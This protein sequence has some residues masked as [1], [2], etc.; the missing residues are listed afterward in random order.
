MSVSLILNERVISRSRV[1][2]LPNLPPSVAIVYPVEGGPF[3]VET[4]RTFGQRWFGKNRA[5]YVVDLS[6]HRR[7]ASV[8]K[9]PLTCKDGGHR[10]QATIDVGFR[11]HDP[12]MVV[13]RNVR[14]ALTVVYGYLTDRIRLQAAR[15]AITEAMAAQ[16]TVNQE[17]DREIRLPEGITI[18]YCKVQ[19]EPDQAAARH[20]QELEEARRRAKLGAHAHDARRSETYSDEDI[21]DIRAAGRRRRQAD[22]RAALGNTQLDFDNLIREHLVRHPEE[23]THAL[24]LLARVRETEATQHEI[25]DQRHAEMVKYLIERGVVREV[26]LP[27]LRQGVLGPSTPGTGVAGVLERPDAGQ[28]ASFASGATP[29]RPDYAAS[30][31]A[32]AAQGG[33]VQ[34]G[35]STPPPAVTP[36]SG[37]IPVYVV[38]DTS[39]AA[40]DC[41]TD[42]GNALR[43]V[44][45][46]LANS[47]DV[48]AA[49]RLSV[50]TY[51][52]GADVVLRLTEV[53]WRTG[54]PGLNISPGCRYRPVLR[55]LLDLVPLE[56]E[57]L[58]EQV[59]RVLR[60][61]VFFLAVGQAED[62][63]EW[64]AAHADLMA[65]K[66][67]PHVVACGIGA[68]RARVVQR[69]ASRPELGVVAVEGADLAQSAVQFSVLL[70]QTLLHLGRSAIAGGMELR[71]DCPQGLRPVTQ[72]Q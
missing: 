68:D 64:P 26:D 55:R 38:L 44:Q 57:R 12:A 18:Y 69:L 54:V 49:I 9:T 8:N 28:P 52:D 33:P 35:G 2:E 27:G 14:D 56:T 11:V 53:S 71:L 59:P 61:V 72:E 22:E 48:A 65:H 1:G 42:L 23:T 21:E 34:W 31:P 40:A 29:G 66:Y 13:S 46:L 4:Y 10:F 70:Q 58:K 25:R 7:Q 50:I 63:T 20:I 32:A 60:P 36:P 43:S 41:V 15:F 39:Q 5:C 17:L 3:E 6:D 30:A 16:L 67:F 62:D 51:A 37:L 24:E 45:T 19:M 47:P